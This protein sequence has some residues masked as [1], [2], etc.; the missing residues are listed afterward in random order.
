MI[1]LDDLHTNSNKCKFI[2][3]SESYLLL[4]CLKSWRKLA[5]HG[6]RV[7]TTIWRENLKWNGQNYNVEIS[8]RKHLIA[9]EYKKFVT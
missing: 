1:Y 2:H 5:E 3:S 8:I 9:R 4:T 7:R 6:T